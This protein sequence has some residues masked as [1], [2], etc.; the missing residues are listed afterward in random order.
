[1]INF[2]KNYNIF[3]IVNGSTIIRSFNKIMI[4]FISC[5]LNKLLFSIFNT[6]II[7]CIVQSDYICKYQKFNIYFY[8]SCVSRKIYYCINFKLLN[9][10]VEYLQNNYRCNLN[11]NKIK[12]DPAFRIFSNLKKLN[13]INAKCFRFRKMICMKKIAKMNT[14]KSKNFKKLKKLER[15]KKIFSKT[16]FF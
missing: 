1:M 7:Y 9:C 16:F 6:F 11:L 2:A 15:R 5:I 12:W 8:Q 3:F 14:E 4:I 13:K 10:C